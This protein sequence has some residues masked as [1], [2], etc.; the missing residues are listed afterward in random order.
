MQTR[1][2][3]GHCNYA[4][5][6]ESSFLCRFICHINKWISSTYGGWWQQEKFEK[7]NEL[8]QCCTWGEKS[9]AVSSGLCW[10]RV[11]RHER[12]RWRRQLI[13]GDCD[14]TSFSYALLSLT[15]RY[16][17]CDLTLYVAVALRTEDATVVRNFSWKRGRPLFPWTRWLMKLF[18][19]VR[20]S[21][22]LLHQKVQYQKP[23]STALTSNIYWLS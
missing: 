12:T 14:Y 10:H 20:L 7:I 19:A 15:S 5:L 9:V 8:W 16:C 11:R 4:A 3:T 18:E 22:S 21:S 17:V 6:G 1:V 23:H 13:V 2:C